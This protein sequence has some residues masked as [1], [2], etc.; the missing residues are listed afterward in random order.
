MPLSDLT[1]RLGTFGTILNTD[2]STPFVDVGKV[3]GLDSAPFR[4]SE[5]DMKATMVDS[6]TRSS[7]KLD[8]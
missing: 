4:T 8:R 3:T 2:V 5:R 6:W 1:F 7:K